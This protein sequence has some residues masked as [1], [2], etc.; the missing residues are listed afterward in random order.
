MWGAGADYGLSAVTAEEAWSIMSRAV[1]LTGRFATSTSYFEER[2]DPG[3]SG[4]PR[5][6][7]A[8]LLDN[9]TGTNPAIK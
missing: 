7:P 6:I 4:P 9:P 1:P 8:V 5:S 2:P 3:R